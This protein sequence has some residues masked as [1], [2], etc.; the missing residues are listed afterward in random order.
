MMLQSSHHVAQHFCLRFLAII[1]HCGFIW[2]IHYIDL[3]LNFG[4]CLHFLSLDIISVLEWVWCVSWT[5]HPILYLRMLVTYSFWYHPT[6]IVMQIVMYCLSLIN[7]QPMSISHS[8]CVFI[9]E[10]N[11]SHVYYVTHHSQPMS[12]SRTA[13]AYSYWR[14][15]FLIYIMWHIIH[16]Q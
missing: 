12:I 15:T 4:F 1:T 13:H 7:S 5:D 14:K 10:K 6:C 16:N 3:L 11:L 8:T 2:A 9:L